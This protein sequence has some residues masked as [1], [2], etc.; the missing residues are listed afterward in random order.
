MLQR[1]VIHVHESCLVH[2][3]LALVQLIR[4]THGWHSMQKRILQV[5]LKK[6]IYY[7]YVITDTLYKKPSHLLLK[8]LSGFFQILK[9]CNILCGLNLNKVTLQVHCYIPLLHYG[10]QRIRIV[11]DAKEHRE[12]R[13]IRNTYVITLRHLEIGW[14]S[15]TLL[16]RWNEKGKQRV[17]LSYLAEIVFRYVGNLLRCSRA[18]DW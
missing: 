18:L 11:L 5:I 14:R 2:Q 7:I 15:K 17:N 16:G 1:A 10:P 4:R 8:A 13:I 9:D 3:L 12:R 6:Y